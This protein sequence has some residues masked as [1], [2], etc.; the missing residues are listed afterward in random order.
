MTTNPQTKPV[1]LVS[2]N[3]NSLKIKENQSRTYQPIQ[4]E[5]PP[6]MIG[7]QLPD[8]KPLRKKS[9]LPPVPRFEDSEKK[10]TEME[11][12]MNKQE[13]LNKFLM[14]IKG[15]D[16]KEMI[17]TKMDIEERKDEKA[18]LPNERMLDSAERNREKSGSIEIK[19]NESIL[20][21]SKIKLE[22]PKDSLKQ[23]K[24]DTSKEKGV[25]TSKEKADIPKFDTPKEKVDVPKEKMDVPKEKSNTGKTP[26]DEKPVFQKPD[27]KLNLDLINNMYKQ[28]INPKKDNPT[29]KKNEV[30]VSSVSNEKV[31]IPLMKKENLIPCNKQN[32]EY[33]PAK[34]NDYESL[35]H[36]RSE[37][38]RKQRETEKKAKMEIEEPKESFKDSRE[39]F[40]L[41]SNNNNNFSNKNPNFRQNNKLVSPKSTIVN[42]YYYSKLF[43][44]LEE[45]P[46]TEKEISNEEKIIKMM[47]KSGWKFGQGIYFIISLSFRF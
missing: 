32:E 38:E 35:V 40:Q 3:P 18:N 27:F 14:E 1:P 4:Q 19:S 10:N 33:D 22:T 47:E 17:P 39:N 12:E 44:I 30:S 41:N 31:L 15:V 21:V 29:P 45:I 8:T 26:N 36:E 9:A 37:K 46:M 24:G 5:S 28:Q 23:D 2:I 7:P 16:F 34:P 43:L 6:V 11:I 25:D 42:K 13:T 20:E